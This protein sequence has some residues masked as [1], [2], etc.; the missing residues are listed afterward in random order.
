[1]RAALI[2]PITQL[3]RFGVGDFHLLLSHL[4]SDSRYKEHYILQRSM[5]S[6]LVLDNSAHE[7]GEG[8]DPI[9]LMTQAR[10]IGAQE[11]V[12]P[13]VLFDAERT[14]EA[15]ISAHEAWGS[16]FGSDEIPALMYVP[17]GQNYTE[18]RECLTDLV[19]VHRY[20]ANRAN[21]PPH[22]VLGV[23]KDYEMWDGGLFRILEE[24][25]KPLRDHLL[26]EG[27]KMQ[28][29]MLGWGRDIKALEI[30]AHRF[31]WIRS[32]DSA[33][34]FVYALS[35]IRINID[36]DTEEYPGRPDDYF[37]RE[38]NTAEVACA[39]HNARIF[40]AVA[41]GSRHAT[42]VV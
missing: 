20:S 42:V 39:R 29:H 2:P 40:R 38:M 21:M 35:G 6:Y 31:P 23:S 18:W 5:G 25:V 28:V 8:N 27:V 15:A 10:N 24:T 30:I 32:T 4:L 1:M 26:S 33:K 9:E 14:V 13:D 16:W 37:E 7:Q 22:L 19:R 17:Q 41:T 12:V 36:K 11:V 3:K 34:P